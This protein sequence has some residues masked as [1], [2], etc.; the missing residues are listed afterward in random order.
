MKVPIIFLMI[1]WLCASCFAQERIQ[2]QVSVDWWVVPLFAVDR[3]GNAITD[4]KKEELRLLVNKRPADEFIL[5]RR[6]FDVEEEL[7]QGQSVPV[8]GKK[9]MMFLIFDNAFSSM[10]N[11]KKSIRIAKRLV[12]GAASSTSFSI[13]TID[14]YAGLLY[15]GGE[16]EQKAKVIDLIDKKVVSNPKARDIE[17]F[18]A[19]SSRTQFG[20]SIGSFYAD[21]ETRF[22][23]EEIGGA[24]LKR[25]NRNYFRSLEVLTFAMNSIQDNKFVYL[26][27][28]GISLSASKIIPRQDAEYQELISKSA[29]LLGRSGAVLFIIN[30]AGVTL[31]SDDESS[32]EDSLRELAD[33]SGGRYLEGET[34]SISRRIKNMHRAYYEIAFPENSDDRSTVRNIVVTAMRPGVSVHTI[35]SLEKSRP[36]VELNKIEKEILALNLIKRNPFFLKRMTLSDMIVKKHYQKEKKEVYEI[37]IPDAWLQQKLDLYIVSID[38]TS[39]DENIE[40][41]SWLAETAGKTIELDAQGNPMIGFVVINPKAQAALLL[42]PETEKIDTPVVEKVPEIRP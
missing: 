17:T 3:D 7:P 36:Y 10:T 33:K 28:E 25:I 2:E 15:L 23:W 5:T 39:K 40:K 30:P 31:A 29:D 22:F 13:L 1:Y 24:A 8:V 21:N 18:K 34:K 32:G 11:F 20:S 42:K 35:H 4:L 9:R 41:N 14:P 19:M 12:E 26:F 27:S 37:A 38:P 16:L 6:L